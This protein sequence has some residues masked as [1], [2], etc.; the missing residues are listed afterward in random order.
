MTG[1]DIQNARLIANLSLR[2]LSALTG[3]PFSTIRRIENDI[4]RTA[5][6]DVV[7]V[8]ETLDLDKPVELTALEQALIHLWRCGDFAKILSIISDEM[9]NTNE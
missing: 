8:L 7:R 2:D 5:Y 6:G 3:I 1:K 4:N 9:D